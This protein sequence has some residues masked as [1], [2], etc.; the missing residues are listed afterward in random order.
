MTRLEIIEATYQCK[1]FENSQL[2]EARV[3][4]TDRLRSLANPKSLKVYVK[5][6]NFGGEPRGTKG[7]KKELC[8]RY[9]YHGVE[10]EITESEHRYLELP[11]KEW[12]GAE[13]LKNIL[14]KVDNR[15]GV[16]GAAKE[17]LQK[18]KGDR[19]LKIRIMKAVKAMGKT[20]IEELV[21]HPAVNI[22]LAGLDELL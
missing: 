18:I 14:D 9:R 12:R 5:N 6:E 4:V 10:G 21:D 13:D 20:A 8:V 15:R 1:W 3:N 19:E 16:E 2:H 17:A 22:V 11:P 7:K